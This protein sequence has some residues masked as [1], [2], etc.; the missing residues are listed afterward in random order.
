MRFVARSDSS[1]RSAGSAAETVPAKASSMAMIGSLI[2]ADHRQR[3]RARLARARGAVR[4]MPALVSRVSH[5]FHRS[6][7]HE[8]PFAVRGEGVYLYDRDG[9]RYLDAS[10]G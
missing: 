4:A 7:R 3:A 1:A 6:L 10:G 8:Y 9:R 2:A 5:V